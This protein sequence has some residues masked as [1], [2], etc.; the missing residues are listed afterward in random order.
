[1]CSQLLS[2]VSIC[3]WLSVIFWLGFRRNSSA[4]SALSK[5]TAVGGH[6]R[7]CT[8]YPEELLWTLG[9]W[10]MGW[11]LSSQHLGKGN[12]WSW[13]SADSG[14]FSGKKDPQ[15][16][17]AVSSDCSI[18]L[19]IHTLLFWSSCYRERS[20]LWQAWVLH[21]WFAMVWHCRKASLQITLEPREDRHSLPPVH[22][23]KRWRL[24]SKNF[25]GLNIS[26]PH[27]KNVNEHRLQL[28]SWKVLRSVRNWP[29]L[30]FIQKITSASSLVL[31]W[32]L[33]G[34][35]AF[36]G[37][38]FSTDKI[39]TRWSLVCPKIGVEDCFQWRHTSPHVHSCRW[40]QHCV[41]FKH[42]HR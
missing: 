8:G 6:P 41:T 34:D 36:W 22:Q 4:V 7:H 40:A 5:A 3:C 30:H 26:E 42:L 29:N 16:S 12:C 10:A 17:H 18:S 14:I 2:T 20:L 21:R 33:L 19:L 9:W 11:L 28:F 37:N 25:C 1:M 15:R 32:E 38:F 13:L 31:H 35:W 24:S 23:R 39:K 27:A